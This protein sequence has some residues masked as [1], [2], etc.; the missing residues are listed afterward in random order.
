[1]TEQEKKKMKREILKRYE[2]YKIRDHRL[3]RLIKDPLRTLPFYILVLLS[4]IKPFQIE[5]KT[6]WGDKIYCYLPDGNAIFYYGCPGEANLTNF[7]INFLKERDVFID[8]GAHLG[9]YSLLVARLVGEQGKVYSFEPTPRTFEFLKKNVSTVLNVIINQVAVLDEEKSI[10]FIDY[11]PRYSAFNTYQERKS[12]DLNFLQKSKKIIN[13]KTITLDKYCQENDI[14]P[15]F[16]KIDAEGAEHPILQGMSY[17]LN[18]LRPFISLEVAGGDEWK[19][20]CQK[21]IQML[22][23]KSY[24]VF[25]IIPEG[26]LIPHTVQEKYSYNN[27]NLIFIP[28]E[29][30]KL[31]SKLFA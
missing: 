1:M 8:I 13:V 18:S 6:L 30:I 22:L 5:F 10:S 27:N 4:K 17:I 7:F 25:E 21:S 28:E 19:E 11:G 12:K 16:I 9:F 29:K 26:K 20:N 2:L 15:T 24:R 3:Q 23:G 14:Q 31:Y